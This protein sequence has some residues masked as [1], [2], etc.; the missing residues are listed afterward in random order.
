MGCRANVCSRLA[1][2]AFAAAL[3]SATKEPREDAPPPL[4][5]EAGGVINFENLDRLRGY[6]PEPYWEN[7]DFFF[8]EG[9]S[10]K[11]GEFYKAYPI[12]EGRGKASAKFGG[13]A[14]IGPDN[15]LEN[16]T[17][18]RPFPEID[19]SDPQAGVKHAWNFHYKH[20]ALEGR[21]HW[22]FT[23][24]DNGDRLPLWFEG[25][26]WAMRLANR[27]DHFETDGDIFN[28]EKRM[29][30]GGFTVTGPPDYRGFIALGYGYKA[31]DKPRDERREVDVWV[32]IPDLR[33][34]RRLSGSRRTDP[35]AGT[36]MTSEDQG[37]FQGVRTEFEW[38]YLGETDVLAP[39]D[40]EI[41][42]YPLSDDANFGP[43]G[44]S[45]ANDTWQLR[46]AII[47]E[48][49]PKDSHIYSRKRMWLDKDTYLCLYAAAYDRRNELWK[50]IQPAYHWSERPDQVKPIKGVNTLIPS[51]N[52]V[53]NV[54]TGTGVRIEVYDAQPTRLSRGKI[55]KQIDIGRLSRQGR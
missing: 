3:V 9:M 47:L 10:L 45:Y 18:G 29:G 17:M 14:R 30:A 49:K 39:I 1:L 19:P 31:G 24:W 32:Y 54:Q 23:Y 13:Q 38:E 26:G 43:T 2:A 40:S 41:K 12:S 46:K 15:S 27:P 37:C 11:I 53:V 5:F 8:H 51:A 20:D 22:L 16:F 55:R 33:R 50:I 7:R 21:G 28:K 48:Q 34:V 6:I 44:F 36:D 4:P 35:I 52:I 42:G 25:R